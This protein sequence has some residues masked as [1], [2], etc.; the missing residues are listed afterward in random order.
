MAKSP[1]WLRPGIVGCC[2]SQ[3]AAYRAI[4]A[5][6]APAGMVLEDDVILPDDTVELLATVAPLLERREVALLYYPV[7][8]PAGS[9]IGTPCPPARD[10]SYIRWTSSR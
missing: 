6:G 2:L 4:V 5:D 9:A 8:G 3:V 1:H 10:G 7:S